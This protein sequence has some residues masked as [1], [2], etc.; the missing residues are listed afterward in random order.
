MGREHVYK[1]EKFL[2]RK[3]LSNRNIRRAKLGFFKK[4]FVTRLA[5]SIEYIE[6]LS[7]IY[8]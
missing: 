7:V 4:F 1:C 8:F 6:Y 5:I 2:C 3:I